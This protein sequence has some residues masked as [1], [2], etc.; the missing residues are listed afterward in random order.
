MEETGLSSSA[1]ETQITVKSMPSRQ[2]GLALEPLWRSTVR[3]ALTALVATLVVIL[4]L[5]IT[6]SFVVKQ[7]QRQIQPSPEE[8]AISLAK[9]YAGGAWQILLEK[10]TGVKTPDTFAASK[11]PQDGTVREVKGWSAEPKGDRHLVSFT[12]VPKGA[13]PGWVRGY[14]FEVDVKQG[15]VVPVV[16]NSELEKKYGLR[17]EQ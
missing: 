5:G 14:W 12:W 9:G 8:Q 10:L 6:G 2:P 11:L 16:G 17:N 1:P 15:I 4:V 13:Q 3:A 7:I